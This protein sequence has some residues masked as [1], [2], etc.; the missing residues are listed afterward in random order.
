MLFYHLESRDGKEMTKRPALRFKPGT[1]QF[2]AP[3][4]G[5]WWILR[6][7]RSSGCFFFVLHGNQPEGHAATHY[8]NIFL[9]IVTTSILYNAM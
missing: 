9:H 8:H 7:G 6:T 3:G 1:S 5:A 2:S 4:T